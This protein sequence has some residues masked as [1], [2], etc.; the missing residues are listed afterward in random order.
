MR[1]GLLFIVI[2]LCI[3]L[4]TGCSDS[5]LG[6]Q[7]T[8]DQ[9][10]YSVE[11]D[12]GAVFLF[13]EPPRRIICTGLGYQDILFDLVPAERFAAVSVSS[14][15]SS[16]SMTASKAKAVKNI[17]QQPA[18]AEQILKYAPDVYI[19]SENTA[20]DVITTLREMGIKVF[21]LKSVENYDSIKH[22]IRKL[23]ELVNEKN[24]GERIIQHME[25][26]RIA[27]QKK[28]A[29][30][31]VE[32]RVAVEITYYGTYGMLQDVFAIICDLGYIKNGMRMMPVRS[33]MVVSKEKLVELDPDVLLL[34]MWD[35]K[36]KKDSDEYYQQ[37]VSDPAYKDIKCIKNKAVYK[38]PEKYRYCTSQY[39]VEAAEKLAEMVYCEYI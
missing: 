3:V 20:P 2:L 15:D 8:S 12:L 39:I 24:K 21:V 4:L 33:S 19:T 10:L 29:N 23:A 34:P 37:I 13:N 7:K 22:N 38:Y 27:L 16:Y 11:D 9:A 35:A 17:F 32:K 6:Y 31:P 18:T 5:S 26:Q 14:L 1:K 25:M 30:I 36:G 28:L